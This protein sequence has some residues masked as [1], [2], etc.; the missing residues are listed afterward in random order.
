M[1]R[2]LSYVIVLGYQTDA[3]K[4]WS[5]SKW[6]A[7]YPEARVFDRGLAFT[8]ARDESERARAFKRLNPSDLDVDVIEDYGLDTE[9]VVWGDKA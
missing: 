8:A 7:E 1:P 2:D 5:G 3:Q 9:K 6:V 4:F